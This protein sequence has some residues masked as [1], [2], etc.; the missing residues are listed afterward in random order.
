MVELLT[1]ISVFLIAGTAEL[2]H[3]ARCRAIAPLAFGPARR[4][5]VWASLAPL[6]R[7]IAVTL[8]AWGMM[9]LMLLPPK[10]HR[11]AATSE[12]KIKHVILVLDVSP[13]MRL[14]DAGPSHIQKRSHRAADIM[15]SFFDRVPMEQYRVSVIAVYTGAKQV[16][17]DTRDIE[18]VRNILEDLPMHHAFNSGDT[19][20]FSGLEAA[21]D[22]AREWKPN[23]TTVLV[24]SDGDTVPATGMPKMPAAVSNVLV[25]GIGDPQKG[26]F[27]NG[28]QSRQDTSTLR[29]IATRLRGIYHNGNEKQISSKTLSMLTKA[30]ETSPL[31]QLTKREYALVACLIGAALYALLPMLL[32]YF[33]TRWTPGVTL[34]EPDARRLQPS[35]R[36][37]GLTSNS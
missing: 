15:E 19:E 36:E 35:S 18:V 26:K 4:P 16:V 20:L 28:R 12:D 6:L 33:G 29:Q 9:T 14:D 11:A 8:L 32:H 30:T 23:S 27:I 31:A 2:L 34:S 1:A 25:V 10:V 17:I 22:V 3:A 21:A 24:V 5:R 37:S 13:S 7:V